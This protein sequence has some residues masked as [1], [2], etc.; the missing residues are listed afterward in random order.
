MGRIWKIGAKSVKIVMI[1]LTTWIFVIISLVP[2]RIGPRDTKQNQMFSQIYLGVSNFSNTKRATA[3]PLHTVL[4]HRVELF[5]C[6]ISS[7]SSLDFKPIFCNN[8]VKNLLK[9]DS[10]KPLLTTFSV[11]CFISWLDIVL[12][13]NNSPIFPSNS[14]KE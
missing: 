14:S 4:R 5:Y 10:F 11:V 7:C 6:S 1:Q 2:K 13:G 12:I 8:P 9:E 3:H